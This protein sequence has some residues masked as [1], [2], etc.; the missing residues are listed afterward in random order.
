MATGCNFLKPNLVDLSMLFG[1]KCD[2]R[3]L[4]A[5]AP[6]KEPLLL[7]FWLFFTVS[8]DLGILN[9]RGAKISDLGFD[10]L[11]CSVVSYYGGRLLSSMSQSESFSWN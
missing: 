5:T 10:L 3:F 1:A 7:E 9:E 2:P 4:L 11:F 8:G 6:A